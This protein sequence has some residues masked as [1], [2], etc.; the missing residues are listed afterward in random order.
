MFTIPLGSEAV[1]T[2]TGVMTTVILTLP[3]AVNCGL[4]ESETWATKVK[5][6]PAVGVPEIAPPLAI[7]N[8]AGRE[9]AGARVQE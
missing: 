1:V 5:A 2:E 6:P 4:L 9:L 7:D 8:P 3:E